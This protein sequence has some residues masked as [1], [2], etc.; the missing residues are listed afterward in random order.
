MRR[1]NER[2]APRPSGR[3]MNIALLCI[4]VLF[5]PCGAQAGEIILQNDS[6]PSA[7]AGIPLPAFVPDEVVAAWFTTPVTGNIVGVQIL[8]NSVFG[9][10]PSS[11]ET[12]ITIYAAG[13][14]PT[15][16]ASLAVVTAPVLTDG[17]INEFRFLDPPQNS[18]AL[19]V[20]VSSGQT[21]VVG[22]EI[23]NQSSGN[24]FASAIEIDQD[25]CQGGLNSVFVIPGGWQDACLLGVTGDFG[26]R[27]IVT[28]EPATLAG[29][30]DSDNDVDGVDF[31]LWQTGYPTA[32]GASLG[33]GDADQD[34]DVDGVD[35]GIWQA[36]YPT[37]VGGAATIPEPATLGLLI[38]DGLALMSRRSEA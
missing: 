17:T 7:G 37:N 11:Q 23:L 19:Q 31:G 33:D 10:N 24:P 32:T 5:G 18:V 14:F 27:A 38:L 21:F 9:G 20:P 25:G 16:G 1:I 12:S 3:R 26:I 22:L 15:P 29:D 30:F 28:P 13:S 34:A 35:F 2:S 36:N 4:A 6:M 8:W